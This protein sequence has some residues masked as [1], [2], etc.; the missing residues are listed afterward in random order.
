MTPI[1]FQNQKEFRKWLE[2]NHK[3]ET[4]LLVGYY[5]AG[6]YK[7]SMTWSQSVD[8]ALCFGWIDGIRRSI[9]NERYCIRFTPRKPSSNWSNIN[10]KKA[11]ELKNKGLIKCLMSAKQETTQLSRL[12]KTIIASKKEKRII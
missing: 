10:I 3:S 5:K 6:S 2:K 1:F 11:E 4:E 12:N 9:D 8:E 7:P